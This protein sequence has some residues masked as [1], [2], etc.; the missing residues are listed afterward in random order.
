MHS[1][2]LRN[3]WICDD[4]LSV[5]NLRQNRFLIQD[6]TEVLWWCWS[7]WMIRFKLQ[8]LTNELRSCTKF[9]TKFAVKPTTPVCYHVK[10]T[11]RCHNTKQTSSTVHFSFF[12]FPHSSSAQHAAARRVDKHFVVFLRFHETPHCASKE[13]A[14][15]HYYICSTRRNLK[16]RHVDTP[17]A[18]HFVYLGATN[19]LCNLLNE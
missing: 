2:C 6:W 3:N 16:L 14:C 18:F 1:G 19:E 8:P 13:R 11:F 5:F 17:F 15:W 7:G 12:S 4:K 9:Q 10:S